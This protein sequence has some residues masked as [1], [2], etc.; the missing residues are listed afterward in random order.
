MRQVLGT[1]LGF[2]K[3]SVVI[4]RLWLHLLL[5]LEHPRSDCNEYNGCKAPE[6]WKYCS[7][8]K[9]IRS[10]G[11]PWMNLHFRHSP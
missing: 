7:L 10:V 8:N 3:A 5:N 1:A 9:G 4:G 6:V 2:P 11:R